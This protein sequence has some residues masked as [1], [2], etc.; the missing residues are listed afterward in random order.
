MWF[1]LIS[2]IAGSIVGSAT[3]SWFRDTKLGIWFYNKLDQIYTWANKRY[4]LKL[5]TDEEDRMKKFPQLS[6]RLET[7]ESQ[8][9][10]IQRARFDD[11]K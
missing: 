4:G 5:L 3:E 6:K 9:K 10:E 8:I 11:W 1:W 7:L 2:A